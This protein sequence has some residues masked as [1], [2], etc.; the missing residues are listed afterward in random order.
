MADF[1]SDIASSLKSLMDAFELDNPDLV[2]EIDLIGKEIDWYESIL[3]S[4]NLPVI[5]GKSSTPTRL[6]PSEFQ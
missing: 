4:L 5:T 1:D 6:A 2:R 3:E